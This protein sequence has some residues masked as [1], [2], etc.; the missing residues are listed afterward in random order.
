MK[1]GF[2]L[3]SLLPGSRRLNAGAATATLDEEFQTMVTILD[4]T[5]VPIE[6]AG[7]NTHQ[8]L[9]DYSRV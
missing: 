6:K 4:G 8:L 3:P 9:L 2:A 7:D 1:A 5:G